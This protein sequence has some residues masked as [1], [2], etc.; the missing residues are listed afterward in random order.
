MSERLAA[1]LIGERL[2]PEATVR[3]AA[4]RQ[5]V[6]GGSLDTALL[7]MGAVSEAALWARLV[8]ATGLPAPDPTLCDAGDG[9][10]AE[11]FRASDSA[12]LRAVAVAVAGGGNGGT[13][14]VL[15]AEPVAEADVRRAAGAS[16]LVPRLYV[17]PEVR[18]VAARH[19]VYGEPPPARYAPLLAK[20]VGPARFRRPRTELDLGPGASEGASEP[21]APAEPIVVE[22][23]GETAAPSPVA[24]ALSLGDDDT[25]AASRFDGEVDFGATPMSPMPDDSPAD[26]RRLSVT[27][28]APG[29]DA[30]AAEDSGVPDR[31]LSQ[32]DSSD[33][34][35]EAMCRRA[36]D[37][38]DKGRPLALRALRSRVNQTAVQAL[39]GEL[40]QA[41]EQAVP[42][43]AAVAAEALAELRDPLAIPIL[44]D[45]LAHAPEPLA[46]ALER[47]LVV[48]SIQRFGRS[49][50]RWG[51]WWRRNAARPRGEWLVEGLGHKDPALRQAAFEELRTLAGDSFGYAPDQPKRD[52]EQAQRRYRVWWNTVGKLR[53]A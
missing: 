5:L 14:H 37:I 16:G 8:A 22:A 15:V 52:R 25:P 42:R 36:R 35:T 48:L 51:A 32:A 46:R 50:R 31:P 28:A 6:Y 18:L 39:L 41:A 53:L 13:V 17:V 4:A 44:V 34:A 30:S 40:R 10:V 21:V 43:H 1:R 26:P 38:A 47:A 24:E 11:I 2:I 20:L 23:T 29:A 7:E 45:R 12:R 33:L 27:S 19:R 49:R 9:A 3:T